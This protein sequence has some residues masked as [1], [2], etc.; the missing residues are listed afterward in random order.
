MAILAILGPFRA[1]WALPGPRPEGLFY[2][3]PSR[4][5][6]VP[7]RP[8]PGGAWPQSRPGT[9]G[10]PKGAGGLPLRGRSGRRGPGV[11]LRELFLIEVVYAKP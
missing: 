1:P 9:G 3:N 5:G 2:I 8:G 11:R 4:R 10:A 7:G 6:P